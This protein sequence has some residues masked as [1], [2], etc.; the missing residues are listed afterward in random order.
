MTKS[1]DDYTE[2]VDAELDADGPT[3]AVAMFLAEETA[4]TVMGDTGSYR[5]QIMDILASESIDAVLTP[6]EAESLRDYVG[7]PFTLHGFSVHESDREPGNFYASLGAVLDVDGSKHV[8]NCGHQTVVAQCIALERL[9]G[10]P[11]RV[12]A[13][14]ANKPNKHG[15]YM[16]RLHKVED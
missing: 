5:Q 1:N 7:Q 16:L 2:I 8:L 11:V 9:D 12:F 15:T 13:Q 14:Q 6:I 4:E 10:F 3:S